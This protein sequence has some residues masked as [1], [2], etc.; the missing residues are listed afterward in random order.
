MSL[1]EKEKEGL[2]AVIVNKDFVVVIVEKD[3]VVVIVRA[4]FKPK[5]V[6]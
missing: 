3:S 4:W 2:V 1:C 6:P 5:L